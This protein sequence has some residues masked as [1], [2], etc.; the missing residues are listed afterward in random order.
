MVKLYSYLYN[1]CEKRIKNPN[2]F[3]MLIIT[4]FKTVP[5]VQ[6]FFNQRPLISKYETAHSAFENLNADEIVQSLNKDGFC[7]GINLSQSIVQELIEFANYTNCYGNGEYQ[8]GFS[9][10]EKEEAEEK[11]GQP[12]IRA[13]Y[14]NTNLLCPAINELASDPHLL[15]I[16]A[17]YLGGN[18]I[19]TGSHLGWLFSVSEQRQH[20]LLESIRFL[21]FKKTIRDGAYFFHYDLDDYRFLKFYFYL[22]DVDLLSGVHV[23]VRGSHKKEAC[24]YT[25]L[26]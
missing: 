11:Y 3:L 7:L 22:T 13:E 17:R 25:L 20:L 2:W 4:Q 26:L 6:I 12:F 21:S 16:A 10:S 1:Y 8:L 19:H 15:E 5:F 9:Y 14:F 24:S 18:P 23:C